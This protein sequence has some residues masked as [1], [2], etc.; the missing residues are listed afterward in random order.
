MA[1]GFAINVQQSSEE[2]PVRY[3]VP[4]AVE[5]E[6]VAAFASYDGSGAAAT[7]IPALAFYSDGGLLLSRVFPQGVTLG[8]GSSADV[9]FGPF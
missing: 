4:G 9:S 3:E 8:A 1:D 7:W 2:A 6:P 5:V